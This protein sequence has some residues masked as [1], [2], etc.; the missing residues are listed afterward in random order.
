MLQQRHSFTGNERLLLAQKAGLPLLSIII[1]TD[2]ISTATQPVR[3]G[4]SYE[5]RS[6]DAL[7]IIG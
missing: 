4:E 2:S 5:S 1:L 3:Q 7:H 6:S